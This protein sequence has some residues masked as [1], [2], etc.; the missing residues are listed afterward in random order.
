[1]GLDLVELVM[2]VE[3]TFGISL[4][5]ARLPKMNTVGELHDCIIEILGREN[6]NI[7]LTDNVLDRL[8]HAMQSVKGT[9]QEQVQ[10]NMF[11]DELIPV[12]GRR[13]TWKKLEKSLEVP[14]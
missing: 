7:G 1:M 14:L 12:C 4:P 2:D 6:G 10:P 5:D 8:R 13:R 11:L 9:S 3:E